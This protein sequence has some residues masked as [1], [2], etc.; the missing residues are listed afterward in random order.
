MRKYV[1][2][3]KTYRRLCLVPLS[4]MDLNVGMDAMKVKD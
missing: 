4:R 2:F 1:Y 3:K